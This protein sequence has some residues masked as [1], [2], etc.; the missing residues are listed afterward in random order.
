MLPEFELLYLTCRCLGN[1]AENYRARNADAPPAPVAPGCG[2]GRAAWREWRPAATSRRH[3]SP[4]AFSR[5][6]G[7]AGAARQRALQIIQLV[8]RAVSDQ[9]LYVAALLGTELV[10]GMFAAFVPL[11]YAAHG[12]TAALRSRTPGSTAPAFNVSPHRSLPSV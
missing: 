5:R 1:L 11:T 10:Y 6:D 9:P 8:G 3:Q 2:P 12:R 7:R 4:C